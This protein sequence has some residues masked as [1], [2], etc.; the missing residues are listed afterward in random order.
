[1]HSIY[2]NAR[3]TLVSALTHSAHEGFLRC[4]TPK[5]A[6]PFHLTP[7]EIANAEDT[8][9][10]EPYPSMLEDLPSHR[11]AWTL[12]EHLMSSHLLVFASDGVFIS[13]RHTDS[14]VE[15][16][17]STMHVNTR[18]FPQPD[19]DARSIWYNIVDSY[20]RREMSH[21]SDKLVAISALARQLAKKTGERYF[22]GI[23]EYQMPSALVWQVVSD[24]RTREDLYRA[25]SW[26]WASREGAIEF[27]MGRAVYR[28]CR[29][30]DCFVEP[31]VHGDAFGP[32]KDGYLVLRAAY[33][34]DISGLT[35]DQRDY[36]WLHQS[37]DLPYDS[38]ADMVYV[39]INELY[40]RE[41][42]P[43]GGI[44]G[45]VLQVVDQEFSQ[46]TR[47]K[48]RRIGCFYY[49]PVEMFEDGEIGEFYVI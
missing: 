48:Y 35:T 4:S 15:D 6:E 34:A 21:A 42:F 45:L 20:S 24:Q 36:I 49:Y 22:A 19:T 5:L 28:D 39:A 40:E 31:L 25:P 41:T 27:R 43:D 37:L 1:M 38:Q 47:K 8:L 30:L 10:L 9:V 11:R 44:S 14:C 23:W 33:C 16:N 26:S 46:S 7:F 3:L 2:R 29:V 13:C 18:M 12:Q 32:V 17:D